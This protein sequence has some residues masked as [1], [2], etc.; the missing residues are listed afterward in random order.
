LTRSSRTSPTGP[1]GSIASTNAP[2]GRR[3]KTVSTSSC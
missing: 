2:T 3:W 1:P